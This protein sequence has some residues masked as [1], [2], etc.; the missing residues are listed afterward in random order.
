MQKSVLIEILHSLSRKEMRDINKW[1]QSPAH[2]QR[3]DVIRLFDYLGKHLSNGEEGLEKEQAW[4]TVFPNQPYDDAYMRQVMYF[5]LKAIE[6]FL[7]F[8]YYTSDGIRYQ[9]ALSRIYRRRKLDKA[10]KQAHRLGLDKLYQQPLRNDFYLLNKFYLEQIEYEHQMNITQNGPVNLQETADALEK[11]FLEE[12][13]RISKDM[14][15]HQSIYPKIQYNHGLLKEVLSYADTKSMLQ[16]PA[17]AVYY[18]AYMAFANTDKEVYFDEL[19]HR[20]LNQTEYFNRL[21]V[22]TLYLAALNYCTVKVNH[23]NLDY[24]RRALKLYHLGMEKGFL[25][26]NN[27]IT[28]YTFGNA[29]AFALKIGEFDWAEQFVERFQHHLDEKERNSIANFN[30]ARLYSE[31]GEYG[32]AQKLLTKFEYDDMVLNLVAKTMLLKIYYEES[33]YDAFESLL[34]AMRTYLHRK[35][36]ISTNYRLVYKNLLSVMRKLIHLNVYSKT[37]K[38]KFRALVMET[39]PLPEREWLLK[40]AD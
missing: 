13:L 40:Q 24:C 5:L 31:K 29:V 17:I 19:E 9:L 36:A 15:A 38:E 32:K 33:A 22:R 6:E 12:R 2:N 28:R 34:D 4:R 37:Q 20:I 1:L 21:E 27:M 3:Q 14:L 7:V 30:L 10:Y 23:G 8:T 35:D 16:E 11:W 39:N 25:L 26:E 18:Y